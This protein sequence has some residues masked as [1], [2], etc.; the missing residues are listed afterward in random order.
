M[1]II[2]NTQLCVESTSILEE[3]SVE[4]ADEVRVQIKPIGPILVEAKQQFMEY[5]E[6]IKLET[7]Q[8]NEMIKSVESK[9]ES[10]LAQSKPA[11]EAAQKAVSNI[12]KMQLCEIKCLR[13]PPKIVNVTLTAVAII[14]GKKI[15]GW[16]DIQKMLGNYRFIP[17]VLKFH[18]NKIKLEYLKKIRKEYTMLDQTKQNLNYLI[19]GYIR[20]NIESKYNDIFVVTDIK[21]LI[22]LF[23]K[24]MCNSSLLIWNPDF[25]YMRVNKAS[26]MAGPLVLWVKAQY[27][28]AILLDSIK[29]M[30]YELKR[31][32]KQLNSKMKR[33]QT[34]KSYIDVLDKKL[35]DHS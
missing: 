15:K 8:I 7:M 24:H 20:E 35:K 26:R 11:L 14:M 4:K 13:N 29:P 17:S 19:Y 6:Y 27:Q 25:N 33:S 34:I 18:T 3:S 21:N 1:N 9:V 31:L 30:R 23:C 10:E 28:C 2:N 12:N 32:K 16:K 22:L 5:F